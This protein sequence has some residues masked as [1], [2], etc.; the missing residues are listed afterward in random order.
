[1]SDYLT[2]L[3]ARS[4]AQTPTIRPRLTSRFEPVRG[5][6]AFFPGPEPV[7]AGFER[8]ASG[9]PLGRNELQIRNA[10]PPSA[11]PLRLPPAA[12]ESRTVEDSASTVG[13]GP[14][15]SEA[16]HQAI[17]AVMQLTAEEG[18]TLAARAPD[19]AAPSSTVSVTPTV[20][21]PKRQ[22][23]PPP[24]ES[25]AKGK[26]SRRENAIETRTESPAVK[27]RAVAPV[28]GH[29]PVP[30]Q[31]GESKLLTEPVEPNVSRP[32]S[33]ARHGDGPHANAIPAPHSEMPRPTSV[34]IV[35]RV[36]L[37]RNRFAAEREPSST[38]AEPI[39]PAPAGQPRSRAVAPSLPVASLVRSSERLTEETIRPESAEPVINVTIGRVEVRAVS[40]SASQP[41]VERSKTPS[42]LMGL[43][44]YLRQRAQGGSR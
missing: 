16:E 13:R 27:D 43:D 4:R 32:L 20:A 2:N 34:L 19:L 29:L 24:I 8:V 33:E 36:R 35:P 6:Q 28:S 30:P 40:S 15:P 5:L 38:I 14:Q 39:S 3:A 1:M 18:R 10:N 44:D 42:K 22:V 37:E 11:E 41:K 31:P 25:S 21:T 12:I 26:M 17:S 23:V 7:V 9:A